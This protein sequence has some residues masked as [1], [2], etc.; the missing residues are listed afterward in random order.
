MIG[1]REAPTPKP[2]LSNFVLGDVASAFLAVALACQHGF[3]S[4]LLT[5]F[6]IE[7]VSLHF[8]NDVLLQN[9]ALE[10]SQRVLKGFTILNVDLRQRLPPVFMVEPYMLT[11]SWQ[12][13]AISEVRRRRENRGTRSRQRGTVLDHEVGGGLDIA[14]FVR[15]KNDT[16]S[17]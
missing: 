17:R 12:G 8:L 16:P 7:S 6:Q 9:L 3:D 11:A 2:P 13:G 15:R 10:A 1:H 5:R 4:L 14:I